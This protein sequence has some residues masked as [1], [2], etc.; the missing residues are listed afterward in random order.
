MTKFP[1][2]KL[3][4]VLKNHSA[5]LADNGGE[6]ADLHGLN[7]KNIDLYGTNYGM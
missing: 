4:T 7:L 1:K 5:W 2:T 3:I 6:M